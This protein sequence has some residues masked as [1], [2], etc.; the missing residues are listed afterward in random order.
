VHGNNVVSEADVAVIEAD[1]GGVPVAK[2][3][4]S[5][6]FL[7]SSGWGKICSSEMKVNDDLYSAISLVIVRWYI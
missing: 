7:L 5:L 3:E 6:W 1:F 4:A 2:G